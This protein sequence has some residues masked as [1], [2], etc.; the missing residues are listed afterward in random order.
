MEDI[1]M[2]IKFG[3]KKAVIGLICILTLSVHC[4]AQSAGRQTYIYGHIDTPRDSS[5]IHCTMIRNIIDGYISDF[6][7]AVKHGEYRIRLGQ[8]QLPVKVFMIIFNADDSRYSIGG[9]GRDGLL[10]NPGD[11]IKMNIH[12]GKTE[13]WDWVDNTGFSGKGS[14]KCQFQIACEKADQIEGHQLN[15]S[16]RDNWWRFHWRLAKADSIISSEID[17]LNKYKPRILPR[18]YLMFK[19]DIIGKHASMVWLPVKVDK[20]TAETRENKFKNYR[21]L[22]NKYS[23]SD[24]VAIGLSFDYMN[25]LVNLECEQQLI[26]RKVAKI[27]VNDLYDGI[28]KNYTPELRDV[29]IS[30]YVK[31]RI[32][33]RGTGSSAIT[34]ITDDVFLHFMNRAYTSAKDPRLKRRF[35]EKLR[36]AKGQK[37]YDFNLP[38]DSSARNLRLSSLRGKVVLLDSWGYHCA[39]CTQ[40]ATTFHSKIYPLFKD[41]SNFVYVSIMNNGNRQQYMHRLR[42]ENKGGAGD[43]DFWTCNTYVNL[44]GGHGTLD[45]TRMEDYYQNYS[46]PFILL[47]DKKGEIYSSA[48]PFFLSPDDPNVQKLTNLIKEALAQPD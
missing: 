45:A 17:L 32:T 36:L 44:F 35:L 3:I 26:R 41:D 15:K 42:G 48:I 37:A 4:M 10:I 19:A 8:L 30:Y 31:D 34:P 43:N 46:D 12:L 9:N 1:D 18:D 22:L 2:L 25:L 5:N 16:D 7:I 27:T 28:S 20:D 40:F 38:L 23:V 11:S 21:F 14:E 29:L 39:P 47:I 6:D 33:A 13:Q 24:V